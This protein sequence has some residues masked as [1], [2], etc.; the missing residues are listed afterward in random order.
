MPADVAESLIFKLHHFLPLA[1][2]S[3]CFRQGFGGVA[4]GNAATGNVKSPRRL[5][6]AR[7]WP[8]NT[9]WAGESRCWRGRVSLRQAGSP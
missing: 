9:R 3:N 6:P 7:A 4:G 2:N 5:L 1:I 8:P